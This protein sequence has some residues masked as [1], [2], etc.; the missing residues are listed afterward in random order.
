VADEAQSSVDLAKRAMAGDPAAFAGLIARHERGCL[1]IAFAKLRN[2][3][4]AGD[5]VQEAFL[6]AWQNI[7][8]LGNP[9]SF[10]GWLGQIVRNLANDCLRTKNRRGT[11][12][13]CDLPGHDGDPQ[14]AAAQSETAKQIDAALA[15]LDETTR[16]IVAL[17]YFDG[18]ASKEIGAIVGMTPTA[19]DMRLSRARAELREMLWMMIDN[20][21]IEDERR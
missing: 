1:A 20:V 2:P 4:S 9:A 18:L 19:V 16:E 12:P 11:E 5:V 8:S 6:K 21:G 14:A 3:D 10:P 13:I 7:K 17:R 15:K